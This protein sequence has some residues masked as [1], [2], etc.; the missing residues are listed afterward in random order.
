[1]KIIKS[2]LLFSILSTHVVLASAGVDGLWK[3]KA[4]GNIPIALLTVSGENYTMQ[5]V[6]NTLWEPKGQDSSNGSGTLK[7]SGAGFT[8]V[9]GPLAEVYGA[10][11]SYSAS[12]PTYCSDGK[13]NCSREALSLDSSKSIPLGCWRDG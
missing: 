3:C 1:M 2:G 12:V 5:A 7:L 13:L 8:A 9:S 11:A 6:K 4:S 10:V